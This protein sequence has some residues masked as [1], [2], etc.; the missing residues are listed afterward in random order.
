MSARRARLRARVSARWMR[1]WRWVSLSLGE[2]Q[3]TPLSFR[4]A[5]LRGGRTIRDAIGDESIARLASLQ[6]REWVLRG[7]H[8]WVNGELREV[9]RDDAR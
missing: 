3:R 1:Y 7:S 8:Q 6:H 2:N 5:Y 4:R 9:R